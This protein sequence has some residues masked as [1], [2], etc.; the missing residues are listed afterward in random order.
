MLSGMLYAFHSGSYFYATEKNVTVAYTNFTLDGANYS[1][2]KFNGV[3]TFL[4]KDGEPLTNQSDI[5]PV[6][7][8]YYVERYYPSGQ[9]LS[10]LRALV[11]TFN[12]SRNN[13]Y[14][15]KNKE[16]YTCRNDGFLNGKLRY[17]NGTYLEC[18]DNVSCTRL[19]SLLVSAYCEH[20]NLCSGADLL[21]MLTN[22]SQASYGMDYLISNYSAKLD[23]VSQDNIV[24]TLDYIKDTSGTLKAYSLAIEGTIFRTPR[25]NDTADRNACK[26]KCFG[27]CPSF[28]LDQ[29][30]ADQIK[31]TATT[32]ANKVAPLKNYNSNS[33]QLAGNTAARMEYAKVEA[34]ADYY[35]DL[36]GG[37]NA[38]GAGAIALGK[39]AK[40][41]VSN[42]TL[43]ANLDKLMA[44]HA[45]IPEDIGDRNF[46]GM[47]ADI[48]SYRNRTVLVRNL[49]ISLLAAYNSTRD[50]KNR[51][52]SLVIALETKDLDASALE[53]FRV[54]QNRTADLDAAFRDGYTVGQLEA[55]RLNY[56]NISAEAQEM[57]KSESDVP[58]L[59]AAL[60]FRGFAR[61]VNGGIA[62]FAVATNLGDNK[63]IFDNRTISFGTFSGLVFLS[64]TALSVLAFMYL[65]MMLNLDVPQSR[66]ILGAAFLCT[67]VI[68]LGFSL[69]LYLFLDKTAASATFTEF[70]SDLNSRNSTS[71]L[72]DLRNV[73]YSDSQSMA[74][75]ADSLAGVLGQKNMTWTIYTLTP[76]T[77][78]EKKRP[79]GNAVFNTTTNTTANATLTVADCIGR[80]ENQPSSFVLGYSAKTEPPAFSVIYQSRAVINANSD[81]Y[82]SCPLV[83]LF[84]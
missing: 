18:R 47:D 84:G 7:H 41:H 55:M 42:M 15:F 59:K 13:G 49:S 76:N 32:L 80:A 39:E 27:I 2:V 12:D 29:D 6:M 3:D 62:K 66:H 51:A 9:E 57:L 44:L 74:T 61:R 54:L 60:L 69:F 81:Y 56:T 26:L 35:S 28:D 63:S 73:S 45:T 58:A 46:T 20:N 83:V 82:K 25:L 4:L 67:I 23:N 38:S 31:S 1:I 34:A 22:F 19:S 70:V 52:D 79:G 77:C 72:L 16:E 33:A 21:P 65:L 43:N 48:A 40:K 78:T 10:G 68:F 36:F 17:P 53:T 71:I 24:A 50:A 8:A 75:C 37:L 30:A 5:E 11:K 64:L 14:D